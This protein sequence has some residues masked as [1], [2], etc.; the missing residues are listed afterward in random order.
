[1][2]GTLNKVI[3]IGYLGRDP[4]IKS[5]ES[6]VKLARFSIATTE[7]F[8]N[9]SGDKTEHTEWHNIVLWRNL[10]NIAELILKKGDQILI[11]GRIR[12]NSWEDQETKQKRYSFEIMGDQ[13]TLLNS[14]KQTEATKETHSN[15]EN[16]PEDD[17]PF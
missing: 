7:V 13:L 16:G 5:L 12:S 11:E 14:K 15:H 1:M 17:L 6:G 2:A 8:K 10:A 9:K 3:L 4:E